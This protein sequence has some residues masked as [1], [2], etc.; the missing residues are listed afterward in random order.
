MTA[1]AH[2]RFRRR[3]ATVREHRA[4][5]HVRRVLGILFLVAAVW[6][7]IWIAQSPLF[8]VTAIRIDGVNRAGVEAVLAAEDV[9]P[10]RPL[11]LIRTGSV[12]A[13]LRA[14][15]WVKDASVRRRF[16]DRVEIEIQERIEVAVVPATDGWK[17]VSDDGRI[18]ASVLEPPPGLAVV[19]AGV[20]FAE[21]GGQM[22]STTMMGVVEFVAALPEGIAATTRIT[23]A[24]GELFAEVGLHRV[25]L[26]DPSNMS[27]KAAALGAL[28]ADGRLA[29]DAVIDLIAP[30]RPA[31]STPAAE[32]APATP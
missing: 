20:G 1:Q 27:A 29:R 15:P 26:G 4:R 22:V 14:D 16:P 13:A 24:G 18:M 2:P 12:E 30:T 32:S 6:A 7:V 5:R 28:L 8:S 11:I 23:A 25:R 19:G 9:Y 21:P 17:T 3:R 31:V 10:G